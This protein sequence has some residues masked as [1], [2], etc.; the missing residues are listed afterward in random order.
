MGRK[1]EGQPGSFAALDATI[2]AICLALPGTKVTLTWGKPHY[3][4]GEKIF[5]GANEE[6][7]RLTVG[8]K[9]DNDLARQTLSNCASG[10]T[11]YF[12]AENGEQLS[13]AFREIARRAIA[14]RLT[15]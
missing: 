4:V 5:A 12:L 13:A 1:D 6:G 14:M 10:P 9:L 7:G 11:F 3:R 15:E 2:R 8:F